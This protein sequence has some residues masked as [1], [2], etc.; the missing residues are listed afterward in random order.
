[1]E[2]TVR[3][4]GTK[5]ANDRRDAKRKGEPSGTFVLPQSSGGTSVQKTHTAAAASNVEGLDVLL[6][7]QGV[8]SASDRDRRAV[9]HGHDL[10]DQLEA[11]RADLL[12]G[13]IS[14]QRIANLSALLRVPQDPDDSAIAQLVADID[15]R[16]RVELAKLGIEK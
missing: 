6:A 14:P 4:D 11:L 8:D 10:L 12:A 3:I 13:N 16:A 15:L 7:L 5:A 2:P 9:H 1:M